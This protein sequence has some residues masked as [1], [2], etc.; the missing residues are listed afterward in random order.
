MATASTATVVLLDLA[1]IAGEVRI[2]RRDQFPFGWF[3]EDANGPIDFTGDDMLLTVNPAADGS[4]SDLFAI[5]EFNTLDA[6]GLV[7]FRPAIADLTQ[8]PATYFFDVQWTQASSSD[9][10]TIIK[11]DFIICDDISD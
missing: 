7:R 9:V 6:T 1:P 4:G 5:A 3:I 10:R 2:T 8:A 11:G